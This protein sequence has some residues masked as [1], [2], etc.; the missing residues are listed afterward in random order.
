MTR[1]YTEAQKKSATKWD[2]ENLD[3]LSVAVPKGDKANIAAHAATMGEST[4]KFINRAI[5]ETMERDQANKI[6]E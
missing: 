4:N 6:T 2:A 5:R 1:K 3:R